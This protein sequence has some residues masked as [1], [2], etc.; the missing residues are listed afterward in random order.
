MILKWSKHREQNTSRHNTSQNKFAFFCFYPRNSLLHSNTK[1][2]RQDIQLPACIKNYPCWPP[3]AKTCTKY[4]HHMLTI[5]NSHIGRCKVVH[6]KAHTKYLFKYI[7]VWIRFIY[8]NDWPVAG[9][10]A[11]GA[12]RR[13]YPIRHFGYQNETT[14]LTPKMLEWVD[15]HLIDVNFVVRSWVQIPLE[16]FVLFFFFKQTLGEY[17][18]YSTWFKIGA[19]V[20]QNIFFIP[21]AKLT[22]LYQILA[23]ILLEI[24]SFG[25]FFVEKIW[26]CSRPG[27]TPNPAPHSFRWVLLIEKRRPT[28][29]R[30][31]I[32][33]KKVYT[34][35]SFK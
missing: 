8:P 6:D 17:W 23:I 24:F 3:N 19:S 7:T 25:T 14:A 31:V 26:V 12:L 34:F 5:R 21:Y 20:Q 18:V 27:W 16:W 4:P 15:A 33:S 2:Y 10:T 1:I 22:S 28:L 30:F 29:A 32:S 35:D 9:R 11:H 13:A